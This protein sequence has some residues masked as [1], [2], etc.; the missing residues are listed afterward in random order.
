MSKPKHIPSI[1]KVMRPFPYS[2]ESSEPVRAATEMMDSHNIHHLPVTEGGE[3]VGILSYR[4]V[5]VGIEVGEKS[6]TK[7]ELLVK[8]VCK[9][10][11][12]SV[13]LNT[14]LDYVLLEMAG[15]HL[16]CAVVTRNEKLVGVF[17]TTDACRSFAEFL[18]DLLGTP[19]GDPEAA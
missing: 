15:K 10:H 4:H 17:T 8:D 9:G 1:K 5:T 13:E 3:L 6:A 14:R 11:P 7:P 12:Y 18:Q 19:E 16:D 2:I